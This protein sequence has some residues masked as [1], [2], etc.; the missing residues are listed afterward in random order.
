MARVNYGC[1]KQTLAVTLYALAASLAV[2]S[3]S[4]AILSEHAHNM[5]ELVSSLD[6]AEPI[7]RKSLDRIFKRD[8]HCTVSNVSERIDCD[9][10]NFEMAETK[11]DSL[12]FRSGVFGSLLILNLT[13]GDCLN[14]EMFDEQFGQGVNSSNCTDGFTCIYRHYKRHWGVLSLGLGEDWSATNCA[15]SVILNARPI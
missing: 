2:S 15:K 4:C 6:R 9:A 8:S 1:M 5:V 3:V 10:Y 14:V 11:I 13:K 7:T 12:D